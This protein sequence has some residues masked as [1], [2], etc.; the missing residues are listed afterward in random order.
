VLSLEVRRTEVRR[1]GEV[2]IRPLEPSDWP[3]VARI[4]DEGIRTG[5]ATFETE[6]PSWE[7]WDEAHLADQRLVAE[8]DGQVVGWAALLSVSRRPVYRGVVEE[9]V[10]VAEE[11]RGRGVG[12]LLLDALIASSERAGIWTIQAVIFPENMATLALHQRCGFR[13]V[14]RRERI[15]QHHGVWRD[16]LILERRSEHL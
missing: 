13:V 9:S 14:G 2:R 5:D 10:Y 15:G 12:R 11:A 16:T 4:Y 8:L 3:A 6:V 7:A 1:A